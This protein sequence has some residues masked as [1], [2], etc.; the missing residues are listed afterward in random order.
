MTFKLDTGA[1]VT[2]ISMETYLQL[3]KPPLL[4]SDKHLSGPAQQPLVVKGHFTCNLSY[5]DKQTTQQVFVV[6]HLKTNLL[7][8][9]ANTALQL[10]L[11]TDTVCTEKKTWVERFPTVFKG[12]GT[13][14]NKYEIKLQPDAKPHAIYTPRHIPLPLRPKVKQELQRMEE[15]GV[16]SKVLDP[17]PWCAGMVIVPKKNN[18]IRICVDLKPLN[19]AVL[20]EVHPLPTVDHTL[21]QLAGAKIFTEL[22]ANSGFWQIP[23]SPSS[24]LLTTF[25]TPEGR[26]CFNNL[27]FGISSAPEVFQR[28]MSEILSGLPG[29]A[30][31]IDDILVFGKTQQEHDQ[32]LEAVLRRIEKAGATL[33]TEKC[34]FNKTTISFLGHVVDPDGVRADPR[35]TEAIANM[36]PPTNTTELRRFLGMA[37]QLGKFTP[38][39]AHI[40]L[41]E[42]LSKSR[43]WSWGPPQDEAFEQVKQ[44]LLKLTLYDPNTQLKVSA[45]SRTF[46]A[47]FQWMETCR[48][49]L[50]IHDGY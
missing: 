15:A 6:E 50:S 14:S 41:R 19:K 4:P 35:M 44:E 48:F 31:Q 21:A 3:G 11:R 42:L 34:E 49:R 36:S 16:I 47:N 25:I 29:V 12:L 9:P 20:R 2:A 28:R 37:N 18:K 22:D 33:S 45:W 10:L 26:F 17:T 40:T 8:L 1:E 23:L 39:L 32:I 13:L 7:G 46:T 43:S 27:P 38:N 5:G 30:C 24:R